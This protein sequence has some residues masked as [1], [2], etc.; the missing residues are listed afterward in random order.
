MEQKLAEFRARRQA[1]KAAKND[2][3]AGSQP[4]SPTAVAA[5][6][7]T[8]ATAD[9]QHPKEAESN[10]VPTQSSQTRVSHH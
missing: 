7:E 9:S 6:S 10:R 3:G 1:E 4:R 8:L 2:Q 5:Q